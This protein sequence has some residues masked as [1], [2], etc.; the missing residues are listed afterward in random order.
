MTNSQISFLERLRNPAFI[1]MLLGVWYTLSVTY[2]NV[3][4]IDQ[5]QNKWIQRQN[6][7][8]IEFDEFKIE[9]LKE[10]NRLEL[11]I[12]KLETE[13]EHLKE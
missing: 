10:I 2:N 9:T 5:R 7:M 11:K 4:I 3:G 8:H 12:T 1:V 6:D 13:I